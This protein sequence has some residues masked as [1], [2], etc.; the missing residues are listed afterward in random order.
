MK[1]EKSIKI[2]TKR[3]GEYRLNRIVTLVYEK[4]VHGW[5]IVLSLNHQSIDISG[6]GETK[7]AAKDEFVIDFENNLPYVKDLLR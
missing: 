7:K 3:I 4:F 1:H 5:W 2:R 6:Y